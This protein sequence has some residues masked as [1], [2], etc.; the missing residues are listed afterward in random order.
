MP[1]RIVLIILCLIALPSFA[2]EAGKTPSWMPKSF[3]GTFDFANLSIARISADGKTVQVARPKIQNQTRT[4]TVNKT[5]IASETRTRTVS[6]G[7][8][9][10]TETYQ[11]EVPHTV[12]EEQMYNVRFPSGSD[13]FDVAMDKVRALDLSGNA[14]DGN[15]LAARLRKPAYVLAME[16]DAGNYTA[17]DPFYVNVLRPD[18]IVM[19]LPPS[20]IPA[21]AAPAAPAGPAPVVLPAPAVPGA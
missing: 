3:P 17:I 6:D 7:G 12:S 15:A 4:R 8:V 1:S 10:K 11:V 19:F 2:Q 21:P 14:I 13:R 18:T 9:E 20:S 5:V 16:G